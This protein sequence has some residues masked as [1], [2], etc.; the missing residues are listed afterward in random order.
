MARSR[1]SRPSLPR[2]DE[3]EENQPEENQPEEPLSE[4]YI[5]T[6]KQREDDPVN[7]AFQ[8]IMS[9]TVKRSRIPLPGTPFL[10]DPLNGWLGNGKQA[11]A[12]IVA[13]TALAA[14]ILYGREDAYFTVMD[15]IQQDRRL[16][17]FGKMGCPGFDD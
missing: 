15:V 10:L 9:T 5:L 4:I 1:A 2:I 7:Y 13:R 16:Y 6:L 17:V 11:V 8:K 12:R 3:V 14:Q